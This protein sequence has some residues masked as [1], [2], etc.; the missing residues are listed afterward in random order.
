MEE[1]ISKRYAREAKT[2]SPDGRT[3][4]L[5]HHGIYDPHKPSKLRVVFDCSAELNGRLINKELLPGPDLANKLVKVLI[6]FRENK[7]AS[8]LTLKKCISKY[9]LLS[10]IE[11][12]FD[13]YGGRKG[14]SQ[15]SQLIMRCVSM[16]LEVFHLEAEAT[17]L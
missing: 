3:W 9:L 10:S 16:Y 12:C 15:R 1:I 6:K 4:Y 11:V 14:T 8:W 2:N 17:T 5:P 13:F 7:V